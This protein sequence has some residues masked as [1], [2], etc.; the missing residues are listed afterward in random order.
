MPVNQKPTGAHAKSSDVVERLRTR[1]ATQTPL[2]AERVLAEELNVTRYQ[3][4]RALMVLRSKGELETPAARKSS[5]PVRGREALI[6]DTNP[7]EVIELRILLEPGFARLAALR[8]TPQDISRLQK[9]CHT[10]PDADRGLTDQAFHKLV[11]AASGSTLIADFYNLLRQVGNDA[12]LHVARPTTQ[13]SA[14][15][16]KRDE[17]HRAIADAIADRDPDRAEAAMRAHLL[18]VQAQIMNR[19]SPALYPSYNPAELDVA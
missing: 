6:R 4:R 10:P 11:A 14:R 13:S 9:A 17:E 15:I 19:I 3:L 8:A 1:L 2:P 12:R 5:S 18:Y 7:L 16:K